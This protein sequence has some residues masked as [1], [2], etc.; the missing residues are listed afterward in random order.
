MKPRSTP[1][2][3]E[4]QTCDCGQPAVTSLM[5]VVRNADGTPF[6]FKLP[7]CLEC[8]CLEAASD[9]LLSNHLCLNCGMQPSR[10]LGR[11]VACYSYF[12]KHGYERP[13]YLY[14]PVFSCRNCGQRLDRRRERTIKG[15]CSRCHAY[16]R[17]HQSERPAYLW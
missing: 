14:Q 12:H 6:K 7:L 8:L 17:S 13:A 15:C 11:C 3:P 5:V 10:T 16:R 9:T 1:H 2:P 4:A